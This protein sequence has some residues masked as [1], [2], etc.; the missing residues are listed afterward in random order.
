MKYISVLIL[1]IAFSFT[2]V[3]QG[4]LKRANR[5]YENAFYF[6]AIPLYE[7]II[8][9]NKSTSVV[10]N[11]ANSYFN[12]RNFNAASRWYEYLATKAG[13]DLEEIYRFRYIQTLKAI[14]N[15][16]KAY[17]VQ[18]K[19]L[20]AENDSAGLV[21]LKKE[22][23][24]LENVRG[25]GNRFEIENLKINTEFSEFGM[26][27]YGDDVIFAAPR[28][29]TG[30]L[31]FK[32]HWNGEGYLDLYRAPKDS[33]KFG[34]T[35][36]KAFPES[37]NTKLHEANAIFTQDGK[38]MYFT[39]NFYLDGKRSADENDVLHIKLFRAHLI[40]GDWKNIEVLPFNGTGYSIEHPAL[41]PD[42]KTLYFASD[43]PGTLGSFDIFK[44]TV[45]TDG[46]FGE[47]I[48]L[49]N[50]INTKYREQF[51]YVSKSGSLYFSSNGLPG[52]GA[53]DVFV[54]E[55]KNGTFG[56]PDNV[57]FPVNSGFD[58]FSF[59][60][61][62]T[63]KEGYFASNRPGG[64]GKD[65]MYKITEIKALLIEDCSQF[66][67]GIITDAETKTPLGNVRISIITKDESDAE[68]AYLMTDAEGAFKF[69]SN[70]NFTIK[71]D[72]SKT[73]YK[74]NNRQVYVGK[75]RGAINDAS[76]E[77][78]SLESIQKK[79][80]N[81]KTAQ[82]ENEIRSREN[83]VDSI[84]ASEK[85]IIQKDQKLM[86]KVE[87]MRFDYNLWYMRRDSKKI[88]N[89]VIQLMKKY[90]DMVVEIG[91]HTDIR[92][93]ESYNLNLSQKRANSAMEYFIEQ[94]IEPQRISA[95][96][97][98]ES[99]PIVRCPTANACD[100]EQ[101]EMNRRCEFIIKSL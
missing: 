63:T 96:G 56:T 16:N 84:I 77:L 95:K 89:K 10:Q 68:I 24:Y 87:D 25:M 11:L 8:K 30:L 43:M 48:N 34:E 64:K 101:H 38:T 41:S 6:E 12:I 92:G 13:N 78:V 69:Q 40:E 75:Q 59:N 70:C 94:G 86:I 72:A 35:I 60:I 53:L 51:P 62:D 32:Y 50:K 2:S 42:E 27:E 37:I 22:M 20:T 1:L 67:T 74:N 31:A 14:N 91:T 26:I 65:D 39:R 61:N 5:Y 90:P 3:A 73:G 33:I 17:A 80:E 82:T 18:E 71:L 93:T 100:E 85:D 97:Y 83:R 7:K 52:F 81:L 4:D 55:V 66:V 29:E 15:Y 36:V 54:S 76:M 79:E 99:E 9:E 19:F 58:D 98:G 45:N 44:V 23:T 88:S 49:G 46:T 57:G 47:P 21:K 28:K